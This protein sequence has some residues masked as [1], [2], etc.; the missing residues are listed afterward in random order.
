MYD[1]HRPYPAYQAYLPYMS[2]TRRLGIV[3]GLLSVAL[4][5]GVASREA[6]RAQGAQGTQGPPRPLGADFALAV[7]QRVTVSGTPLMLR[8]E[9]VMN[10]SRCPQ[11]ARCVTMGDAEVHLS[12]ANGTAK[13]RQVVL[14]TAAAARAQSSGAGGIGGGVR[15]DGAPG[16]VGEPASQP[17]LAA[18]V[19]AGF[20][21]RLIDLA[22]PTLSTKQ[23]QQKDYRVTLRVTRQSR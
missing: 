14:H 18:T 10:D 16:G 22:P 6:V 20:E 12:V 17:M 1:S 7:G 19:E 9:S 13:P 8:V 3:S 11:D 23:L 2:Q 15:L 4:V 21:V 5:L